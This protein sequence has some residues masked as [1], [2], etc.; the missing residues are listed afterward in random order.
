MNRIY[1]YTTL[2]IK[3]PKHVDL[4]NMLSINCTK[5]KIDGL[6]CGTSFKINFIFLSINFKIILVLQCVLPQPINNELKR[7][8]NKKL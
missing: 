7:V 6:I 5:G 3:I 2:D 8:L 1:E 4:D